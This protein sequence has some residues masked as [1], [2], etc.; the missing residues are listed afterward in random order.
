MISACLACLKRSTLKNL[1]NNMNL[2]RPAPPVQDILHLRLPAAAKAITDILELPCDQD[3][4]HNVIYWDEILDV[5][6]GAQYIKNGNTIVR[7]LRDSGPDGTKP[8]RI[9]HHPGIIL[10]VV[11]S[12]CT[13]GNPTNSSIAPSKPPATSGPN[14]GSTDSAAPVSLMEHDV[15][16]DLKVS[17]L[18]VQ[19]RNQD[20]WAMSS[21]TLAVVQSS[22]LDTEEDSSL[23][24]NQVTMLV[25][26]KT[27]ESSFEQRLVT[28]LP[29]D[30]QTQ[31]LASSD[32]HGSIVQAIQNGKVDRL[33]EQLIACWQDLKDEM[34]K[35]NGLVSDV[36]ELALKN[37]ELASRN[38]DLVTDVKDLTLKNMELTNN[39]IKMQ[40]NFDTK[41][42]EMKQ[43][44]I[45][46]LSQL[47]LLQN[48]IQTLMAQTYELHEYPIPRLFVVLPQDTSSWKPTKLFSNKFRLYFLCECGEHTK[49]LNSKIPHHIH[50]AKHEGY[51]INRPT[52]FFV[53]YGHYVLTILRMLRFGIS[54]AGVAIPAV[55]QLV[56]ADALDQATQNLKMLSED[57]QKGMDQAIGCLEKVT[58][59]ESTV[60]GSGSVSEQM[61]NNEALEGADLRKLET[62]LKSKDG[63]KVLGNLYRIVTTEGHVKWVCIDHY[64]E[65][66]QEKAAKA[67]HDAV[68]SIGGSF[69]EIIGR[70][71]IHLRSRIQAE[72]FY[73]ALE[74]AKSVLEIDIVLDWDT[75]QNDLK[76]L[77]DTL[78]ITNV[79]SLRLDLKHHAGPASDILNRNKRHDPILDIMRHPSI[80]S[81]SIIG[82]P[83]DFIERSSLQSRPDI[84]SSL[85]YLGID[86]S[87]LRKDVLGIKA[88][89]SRAPNLSRLALDDAGDG[90][91]QVYNAIAEHQRCPVTFDYVFCH[92]RILPPTSESR[93]SLARTLDVKEL[94]RGHG[95]RIEIV[96]PDR[97]EVVGSITNVFSKSRWNGASLTKLDVMDSRQ[98]GDRCIKNLGAVI[99]WS[100]LDKLEI[101]LKNEEG[102]MQI[103]QWIP[104]KHVRHLGIEVK[105]ESVGTLALKVLVAGRRR[106]SG[107]VE[108]EYFKLHSQHGGVILAEQ[109][110]LLRSLVASTSVK[111][112]WLHIVMTYSQMV[113]VLKAAD[114]SRLEKVRLW[115]STRSPAEV[116]GVLDCLEKA[117]ML[118]KVVLDWYSPTQE[119]RERMKVRGVTIE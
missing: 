116:D 112:L 97:H 42:E 11:L 24:S 70:V 72:Q 17:T 8:C 94:L 63:N 49:S 40:E 90:I 62:F 98:L 58:E 111:T 18:A 114:V 4:G 20:S 3:D 36:K 79:S 60:A 91:V 59:D 74:R 104:W 101:D 105:K 33:H 69:D 96:E 64:R 78:L 12:T 88:L 75:T 19:F 52:E 95:E 9:K 47:S 1:V 57:L 50:L 23:S 30:I 53:Q 27:L 31:I 22:P 119:Q 89:V 65:N 99:A 38:N 107:R 26:T 45:Q 10:D 83:E 84:F 110:E 21:A 34:I 67:F 46:A 56:R 15:P 93:Q 81:F 100:E 117:N 102:R 5:F 41:Q 7:K 2:R 25:P 13:S 48:R 37:N 118:Q 92:V 35:N 86:L 71:T 82:A 39:M 87:A 77:R 115:A 28:S 44:Q 14:N 85:K 109:E 61:K 108:L 16:E 29:P 6:P 55:P 113:S 51:E 68:D 76:K 54:V 43:L 32:I 80:R 103:L 106:V 73:K 66:Y